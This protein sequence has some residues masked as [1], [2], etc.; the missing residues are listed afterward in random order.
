MKVDLSNKNLKRIDYLF[1][2]QYL[3]SIV[4]SNKDEV[5]IEKDEDETIENLVQTVCLDNNFLSKLE[6]L[7]LFHNLKNVSFFHIIQLKKIYLVFN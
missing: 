7:D 2:R 5:L 6:N 4:L 3:K 1:L